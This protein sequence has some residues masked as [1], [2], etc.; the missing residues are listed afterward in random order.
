LSL[1]GDPGG[2]EKTFPSGRELKLHTLRSF[3]TCRCELEECD[4]MLD[5]TLCG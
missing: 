3:V 2:D 4:G 1:F 5:K